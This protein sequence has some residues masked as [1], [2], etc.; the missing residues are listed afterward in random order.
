MSEEWGVKY[1]PVGHAQFA[2]SVRSVGSFVTSNSQLS[3][4]VSLG[5]VLTALEALDQR[6]VVR[7]A[8]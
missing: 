3:L 7:V 2:G 4:S 1:S 6:V 5:R 8:S